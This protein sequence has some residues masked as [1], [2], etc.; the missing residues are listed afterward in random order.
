MEAEA[1]A[2]KC[3]HEPRE[4]S[5]QESSIPMLDAAK[6]LESRFECPIC[7]QCLSEPVLTPCGHRFCKS[8]IVTWL[9]REG[10]VCPVDNQPLN[11]NKDLF[12][13]N[14][15]RREIQDTLQ[16]GLNSQLMECSFRDVGCLSVVHTDEMPGHLDSQI[17]HHI[18]L[19]SAAYSKLR[20]SVEMQQ[21]QKKAYEA[22]SL[23]EPDVKGQGEA[24]QGDASSCRGLIR[25]LYE[26]VVLLE[27]Q[28]RETEIQLTNLKRQLAEHTDSVSHDLALKHCGGVYLWI[29]NNI[30]DK[31]S[32]MQV[33]PT[34]CMF[35][36]PGFYTAP[37][38]YR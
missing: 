14:Y 26:R 19:L 13:D 24:G 23:W 34:R 1:T 15:T 7:L 31:L 28:G 29:V 10:G 35:F 6:N 36:S 20:Q 37:N 27:Q 18:N 12:P 38:G 21:V 9:K 16:E 25:S 5:A 32:A 3:S 11:P 8:C 17:H 30:S 22:S 2:R 33:N 4:V